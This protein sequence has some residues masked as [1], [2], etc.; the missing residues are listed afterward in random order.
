MGSLTSRP[1]VPSYQPTT[2]V[3]Y[4]PAPTQSVMTSPSVTTSPTSGTETPQD[5][6]AQVKA[7]NLLNRD[8]SR[9]GTIT[10]S[11]RGLL[12]L[13]GQNSGRKT[14]LGE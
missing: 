10:T 3:I 6:S 2:Q 1:K 11:F 8:R 12:S 14:L 4:V 13:T 5:N 9:F 7:D